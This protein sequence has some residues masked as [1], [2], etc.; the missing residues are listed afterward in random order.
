[1]S[2]N[3]KTTSVSLIWCMLPNYINRIITLRNDKIIG[4]VAN[5]SIIL[6]SAIILEGFMCDLLVEE[7]N[8]FSSKNTLIDRLEEDFKE[9]ISRSTYKDFNNLYKLKF[10]STIKDDLDDTGIYDSYDCLFEFRNK[11]IHSNSIIVVY[12]SDTKKSRINS[13]YQKVY[14]HLLMNKLIE[15]IKLDEGNNPSVDLINDMV[16][17]YFWKQTKGFIVKLTN[18]RSC[19]TSYL[20]IFIKNLNSI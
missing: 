14:N 17:D 1:M 8:I 5:I 4:D 11:L 6:H 18:K 20:P 16:A 7:I 15:P 10:N 13:Q 12:D 2:A 9:K 19:D 3:C